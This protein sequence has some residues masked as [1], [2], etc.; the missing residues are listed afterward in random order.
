MN[1]RLI[2]RPEAELDLED[3]FVWYESQD[4][5]LGSEFVRAID[6]CISSIGRNPMSYAIVYQEARQALVRRF[7]Y[8]I[9]YVVQEDT[10]FV[11]GFFHSK[12]NPND[13][14]ERL[15]K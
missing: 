14:Q 7:P 6:N 1:Y 9:L 13:W 8:I 2:I 3:A 4:N 5:G 10:V 15:K 11:I 12:R